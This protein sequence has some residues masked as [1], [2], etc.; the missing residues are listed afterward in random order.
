[1][2]C[3]KKC[4]TTDNVVPQVGFCPKCLQAF[5]SQ[6]STQLGQHHAT[7]D[8][9]AWLLRLSSTAHDPA[10]EV[11]KV[12]VDND[13]GKNLQ[14]HQKEGVDF[15]WENGFSD[16][17]YFLDGDE[18][19]I[20]GCIL[21]HYMGLGKSLTLIT[22]LHTALTCTSLVSSATNKPLFRTVLLIAPANTLTNWENEV[23]KWTGELERPLRIVNLG[24]AKAGYQA[25]EIKKWTRDGGLLVMSDSLFLKLADTLLKIAQPDVLALDEAHTMLKRS[26]NKGYKKLHDIRTKRRILLTGTPMQNNVTEYFHMVEFIRPGVIEVQSGHEFEKVFREPIERGLPSDA[27]DEDKLVS[28]QQQLDLKRKVDPYV[29]RKSAT[30]LRDQLPPLY[31]TL[32]DLHPTRIQTKLA[33]VYKRQQHEGD[34]N[35]FKMYAALS[36]MYNH[37]GCLKLIKG[38]KGKEETWKQYDDVVDD[39]DLWFMDDGLKKSEFNGMHKCRNSPKLIILAHILAT[40][41]RDGDKTLVYSKDLNTL[42][43]VEWFLSQSDWTKHVTSLKHKSFAGLKLGGWKK[44]KDFVRIDGGVDSGRR[45]SLV[46]KFNGDPNVK[47]FTISCLAG[48]IGINLCSASVVVLLDNHFNPSVSDQCISRAHRYG[49]KKPVRCFRLAMKGTMEAK[50]YARSVNKS[51]VAQQV[52]DGNFSEKH[53]H[54]SAEELEDLKDF[55][56]SVE[57]SRCG[58]WRSFP[59]DQ[60]LPDQDA[61]WYCE[62]NT[63]QRYNSC[64]IPVEAALLEHYRGQ[65]RVQEDGLLRHL[66]RVVNPKT[67]KKEIVASHTPVEIIHESDCSCEDAIAKLEGEIADQKKKIALQGRGVAASRSDG[68]AVVVVQPKLEAMPQL[69]GAGGAPQEIVDLTLFDEPDSKRPKVAV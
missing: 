57:C 28:L 38:K 63:D 55:K 44:G 24:K 36:P 50:I 42:S 62:M 17:N 53:F 69:P 68:A 18:S 41:V 46:E 19:Q 16:C 43:I 66:L 1:M 15:I 5:M 3:C 65:S 10:S 27:A 12:C 11:R 37:P 59:A 9:N 22:L 6:S 14:P 39:E 13:I 29:H 60:D 61:N 48:G 67:M 23:E 4:G 54:F 45:G 25:S 49:Q 58:K 20:G 52:I 21:A 51:G 33:K 30:V 7:H 8:S 64:T 31:D 47:V 26:G 32:L 56:S 35:F 2:S 34:K 40:A